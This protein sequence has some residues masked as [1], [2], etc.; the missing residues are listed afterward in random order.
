MLAATVFVLTLSPDSFPLFLPGTR[1]FDSQRCHAFFSLHAEPFNLQYLT[2]KSLMRGYLARDIL[3]SDVSNLLRE[4]GRLEKTDC[5]NGLADFIANCNDWWEMLGSGMAVTYTDAE[6]E[7]LQKLLDIV[8]F[9]D[10]WEAQ[11]AGIPLHAEPFNLQSAAER[12]RLFL[13]NQTMWALRQ[14]T[15]A[16]VGLCREYLP[17]APAGRGIRCVRCS[18]DPVE[19]YFV[20]AYCLHSSVRV[21]ACT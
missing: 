17:G 13:S 20:S 3:S 16:F 14:T 7:R 18:Q 9:F 10:K 1:V 4:K 6:D 15:Y 12:N 11:V 8:S 2:P 5:W 19:A 21:G